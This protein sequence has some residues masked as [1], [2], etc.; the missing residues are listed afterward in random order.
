MPKRI[1]ATSPSVQEARQR[2]RSFLVVE[3]QSV[4][5]FAARHGVTQSTVQR[6]L[7]G[8]TKKLTPAVRKILRYAKIEVEQRITEEATGAMDNPRLRTALE[9]AWDGSS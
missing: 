7:A 4:N 3:G 9:Q 6:L 5:A 1:M 2:L 8:R